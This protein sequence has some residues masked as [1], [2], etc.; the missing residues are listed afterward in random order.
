MDHY[1]CRLM[2]IRAGE[3]KNLTG[4]TPGCKVHQRM[5]QGSLVANG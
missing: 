4:G 1:A 3:K 2:K 5:R